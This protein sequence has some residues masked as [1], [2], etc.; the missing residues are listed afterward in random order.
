MNSSFVVWKFIGHW[1]LVIFNRLFD[2]NFSF[3]KTP[4]FLL[5]ATLLFWGWQTGFLVVGAIM[6]AALESA[7]FIKLRWE[8]S[9]DDFN[10]VWTFCTLL[11]LAA[12]VY[13]FTANEGPAR[14]SR[15]FQ[16]S[17]FFTQR[18]VGTASAR[19]ATALL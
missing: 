15:F 11:S 6:D 12:L 4:P 5:G 16:N 9:D 17:N 8:F 3:V 14:F 18:G 10:R 7:R 1:S 19:T 13:A 2:G